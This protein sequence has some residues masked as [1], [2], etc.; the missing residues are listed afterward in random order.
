MVKSETPEFPSEFP[1]G[2]HYMQSNHYAH[3]HPELEFSI[4]IRGRGRYF[5]KDR[6]HS[7]VPG[8]VVV[9]HSN[10]VHYGVPV[11]SDSSV[12]R[13]VLTFARGIVEDRPAAMSSLD[14][15]YGKN[16]VFLSSAEVTAVELLL[17]GL[18]KEAME[19]RPHWQELMVCDVERFL[20]MV[21]RT[22]TTAP[23]LSDKPDPI[24]GA[25]VVHLQE[26]FA[27]R[28][29]IE[30]IAQSFGVSVSLLRRIFK[31]ETGLGLKAFITHLRIME[32]KKLLHQTDA[33]IASIAYQVG[34][35]NL[36]A[37]NRDFRQ[38]TG[39]APSDYRRLTP[40]SAPPTPHTPPSPPCPSR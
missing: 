19:K 20:L 9:V 15:L 1:A 4:V 7:V 24:V 3:Y 31:R 40:S 37:F 22:Q 2:V 17:R 21:C 34:F 8:S 35:E 13:V 18:E 23:A 5:A 6:V 10:E 27:Q 32:A 12:L 29:S 33:K 30:G 38:L 25:V 36:S 16:H 39:L 11:M 28:Q 14:Q 26:T